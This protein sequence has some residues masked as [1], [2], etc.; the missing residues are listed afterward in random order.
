MAEVLGAI[1]WDGKRDQDGTR[2][3]T[4][5]WLVQGL[6]G[7]GPAA[8][9]A[10]SG[11]P[12]IG[13]LWN[14]NSG[15]ESDPFVTCWPTLEVSKV[16]PENEAGDLYK[17]KQTF[18]NKPLGEVTTFD[19]PLSTPPQ[20][21]GSY[22][23]MTQKVSRDMNGNLIAS[24]SK[25]IYEVE[26]DQS[27]PTVSVTLTVAT[28]DLYTYTSLIDNTNLYTLWG[29]SPG[30]VKLSN[31][32]WRK[33]WSNY[34]SSAYFEV[35]LEFEINFSTFNY[36][37]FDHGTRR[38]P[39]GTSLTA[40]SLSNFEAITDKSGNPYVGFLGGNGFEV[41]NVNSLVLQTFNIY[42]Q[43]DL[44]LLGIPAYL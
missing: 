23:K 40:N 9:M 27:R 24:S 13:S 3:L 33:H 36:Y 26:R 25:E 15:V 35:T 12:A 29:V 39:A 41:T 21:S 38:L 19:D 17:V 42:P 6:E 10:A 28:L 30:C 4:I 32:S 11:L 2:D 34:L 18:S 22:I 14:W 37:T 31:V 1:A 44:M 16:G 43:S 8:A 5:T 20:V 7:E